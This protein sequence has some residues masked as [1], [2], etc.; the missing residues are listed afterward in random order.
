MWS[1]L[2]ELVPSKHFHV[3]VQVASERAQL[4]QLSTELTH[5]LACRAATQLFTS[6][7]QTAAAQQHRRRVVLRGLLVHW[8]LWAIDH[9]RRNAAWR[10]AR[11]VLDSNCRMRVF[12]TWRWF[13]QVSSLSNRYEHMPHSTPT[14]L[15]HVNSTSDS[16]HPGGASHLLAPQRL[17]SG[18][19]HHIA[20]TTRIEVHATLLLPVIRHDMRV[21]SPALE[22]QFTALSSQR[23]VWSCCCMC[24]TIPCSSTQVRVAKAAAFR[25]KQAALREALALGDQVA[26]RRKRALLAATFT[27]WHLQVR[28][29]PTQLACCMVKGPVWGRSLPSCLVHSAWHHVQSATCICVRVCG[30]ICVNRF[31]ICV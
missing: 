9:R 11:A 2:N 16:S 17:T 8:L 23:R 19:Q 18:T 15:Y 10:A 29:G 1:Q 13:T 7:R 28:A 30:C 25:S 6:W 31:C 5:Q 26:R 24:H 3:L 22:V 4:R 27:A 12:Y 21:T 20:H 14:H